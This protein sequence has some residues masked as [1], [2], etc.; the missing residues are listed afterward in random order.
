MIILL[1]QDRK[2]CLGGTTGSSTSRKAPNML[3][4]SVSSIL[5]DHVLFSSS[6]TNI[7]MTSTFNTQFNLGQQTTVSLPSIER[8]QADEGDV[9]RRSSGA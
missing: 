6:E 4:P 1:Q 7:K 5:R 3:V 9:H 2:R 8:F